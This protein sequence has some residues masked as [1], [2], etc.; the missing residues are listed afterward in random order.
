MNM[1]TPQHPLRYITD[2][3]PVRFEPPLSADTVETSTT[4]LGFREADSTER[5]GNRHAAAYTRLRQRINKPELTG[6]IT[7]SS[8]IPKAILCSC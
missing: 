4:I 1:K 2:A 6:K 7:V 8:E 3:F 5:T